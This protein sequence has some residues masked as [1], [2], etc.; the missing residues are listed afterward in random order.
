MAKSPRCFGSHERFF[1]VVAQPQHNEAETLSMRGCLNWRGVPRTLFS[2]Y[3]Y[4][5][6]QFNVAVR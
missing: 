6:V 4:C 5:T 1:G 3:T 2:L